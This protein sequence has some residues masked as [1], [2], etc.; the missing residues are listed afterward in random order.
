MEFS[1]LTQQKGTKPDLVIIQNPIQAMSFGSSTKL[2][3]VLE[4]TPILQLSQISGKPFEVCIYFIFQN[5]LPLL[6]CSCSL[7]STDYQSDLT[8]IH[9]KPNS[10]N[11]AIGVQENLIGCRYVELSQLLGKNH[12]NKRY[13]V[14]PD[15]SVREEGKYRLKFSL[16]EIGRPLHCNSFKRSKVRGEIISELFS[17]EFIVHRRSDFREMNDLIPITNVFIQYGVQLPC[18]SFTVGDGN[19]RLFGEQDS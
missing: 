16:C 18:R 8:L 10:E 5:F 14:F 1:A 13:F 3:R 4:P 12:T 9:T 15:L 17:E 7:W 6:T 19:I 2:R 11:S